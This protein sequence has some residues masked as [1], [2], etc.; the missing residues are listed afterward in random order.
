M[1]AQDDKKTIE[2][3]REQC[4]DLRI[5]EVQKDVQTLGRDVNSKLNTIVEQNRHYFKEFERLVNRVDKLEKEDNKRAN[6]ITDKKVEDL[7]KDLRVLL[8]VTRNRWVQILI[9]ITLA[10]VLAPQFKVGII[11]LSKLLIG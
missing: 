1:T 7:K 10:F 11:E 2:K 5:S 8:V 6:Q 9:V 4:L 3:L